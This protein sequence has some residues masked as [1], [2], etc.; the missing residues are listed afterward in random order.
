MSL[1]SMETG[2]SGVSFSETGSIAETLSLV[3][4]LIF[5]CLIGQLIGSSGGVLFL[6]EFV[7]TS[8]SLVL[9]GAG[10]ISANAVESW[11]TFFSLGITAFWGYLFGRVSIMEGIKQK[12]SGFSS[13]M[14]CFSLFVLALLWTIAFFVWTWES[15][16]EL[17]VDRTYA[18]NGSHEKWNLGGELDVRKIQ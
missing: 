15:A 9:G 17:V 14:L 3:T 7:V 6:A 1:Q 4:I 11:G 12:R 16:I 8:I 18:P 2:R 5:G 10:T 13:I